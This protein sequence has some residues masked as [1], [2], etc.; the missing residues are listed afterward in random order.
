MG[1]VGQAEIE[2]KYPDKE[3]DRPR[4]TRQIRWIDFYHRGVMYICAI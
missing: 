2:Q 1:T 3:V 4:L